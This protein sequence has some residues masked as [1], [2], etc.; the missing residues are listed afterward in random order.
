MPGMGEERH[1]PV[2][3][4]ELAVGDA[5]QR[6]VAAVAVEEDEPLG[7]GRGDAAADV[8]EHREQ[9]GCRQPDRARRPRV[10]VRLG[11]LQRRQ[12]P[13]VE[14]VADLGDGRLGDRGRRRR[15]RC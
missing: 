5:E 2:L 12:Q 11:V 7:R 6:A 10:L 8:V 14:L 3:E 1:Q 9:R 15:S 4:A 13:D